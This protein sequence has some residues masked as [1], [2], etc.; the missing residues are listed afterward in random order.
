V[1]LHK[2]ALTLKPVAYPAQSFVMKLG[3]VGQE[4]YFVAR[5]EVEVLDG[6]GKQLAKLREGDF[7]GELSLLRSEPRNASIRTTTACDLFVLE[8]HD[9]DEAMRNHPEFAAGLHDAA[10]SRYRIAEV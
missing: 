9:F 5:G 4:M 3:D 2:L 10:R 7:F 1:F 8:K 6:S